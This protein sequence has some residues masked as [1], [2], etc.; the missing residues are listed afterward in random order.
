M[1]RINLLPVRAARKKEN[2]RRQVSVF[3]LSVVF[4]LLVI[5]YFWISMGQTISE[6]R[7]NIERAQKDLTRYQATVREANKIKSDLQKLE[8]KLAVIGKLEENRSGPVRLMDGL[9]RLVIPDK[10]WLTSLSGTE[11]QMTFTGVATDNKT[12]A[13]FMTN[14]EKS[15]FFGVVNL[16]SSKQVN[17][18]DKKFKEFTITC[19]MQSVKPKTS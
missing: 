13:D 11:G 7:V 17:V 18:Q 14:L 15:T 2:I 3:S 8:Q 9:T 10:M 4:V 19:S 1:I 16:I 6:L 5:V 12:V